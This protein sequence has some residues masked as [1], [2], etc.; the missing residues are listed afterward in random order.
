VGQQAFD[1]GVAAHARGDHAA[2]EASFRAAVTAAPD[3]DGYYDL[4]NAAWRLERPALAMVA[5]HRARVM[6]PRDPDVAANLAHARR[7]AR[8]SLAAPSDVPGWAPWQAAVGVGEALWV[9]CALAGAGLIALAGRRRWPGTMAPG[10]VGVGVGAVLVAGALATTAG[11]PLAVVLVDEVVATSDPTGGA[12]LFT[13]HAR[14]EVLAVDEVA[15]RTLVE[16]SD[17]R[18]GWVVS[19]RIGLCDPWRPFPAL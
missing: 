3:V 7:A 1:A 2:A 13:L 18:R 15:A 14:A 11:P 16:L 19:D 12:E 17:G 10:V 9:G 6:N 8:D 5:W 4:G